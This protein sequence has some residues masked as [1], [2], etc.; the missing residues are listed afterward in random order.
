MN[1]PLQLKGT[2]LS[3]NDAP[4]VIAIKYRKLMDYH[5]FTSDEVAGLHVSSKNPETA[6][7][8]ICEAVVLLK[9]LNEQIDCTVE[10]TQDFYDFIQRERVA[11]N[12]NVCT[13]NEFP[14][15]L[16]RAA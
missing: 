3:D 15:I 14:L 11:N 16:K 12:G 9:W 4:I 1:K 6:V 8:E 2:N 10:L 5:V 7:G 13:K